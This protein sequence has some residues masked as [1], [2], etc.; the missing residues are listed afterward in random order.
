[1]ADAARPKL[2]DR[3][4]AV[5]AAVERLGRP[6]M[7]D[8]WREFPDLAPSGIKKVLDA[9]EKKGLVEH[10]GDD[11]QAFVNG[12]HWW[13]TALT[14]TEYD[15]DL[16]AIVRAVEEAKLGLRHS[17][18]P[19]DRSVT[20]FLPLVELESH[21][22]GLPSGPLDRLRACVEGTEAAGHSLR[23]TISTQITND[24][25]PLLAVQLRPASV[26]L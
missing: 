3:Q 15:D 12:V 6:V 21:L 9:L 25:E 16:A 7:A 20:V 17:A 24:P 2:T 13:S 8:L 14:P 11:S 1:M 4:T 10:A 18:D 19:H 22:R 5:L 23:L 26:E